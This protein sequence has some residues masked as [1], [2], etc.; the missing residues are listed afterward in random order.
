MILKN[1]KQFFVDNK[2]SLSLHKDYGDGVFLD[3]NLTFLTD[4]FLEYQ[5]DLF[6]EFIAEISDL[7]SNY[8]DK[9][10]KQ[11]Q[12][13]FEESLQNMNTKLSSFAEKIEDI[14][15]FNIR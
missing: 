1:S 6:N 13:E 15:K 11:F 9:T 10:L 14:D 12:E 8:E 5:K 4:K 3:A 2:T 7:L